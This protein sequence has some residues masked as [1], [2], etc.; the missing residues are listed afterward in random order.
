M[1]EKIS[2]SEKE[3]MAICSSLDTNKSKGADRLP[4]ILLQK[5]GISLSH[6]LAQIFRKSVQTCIFPDFWK[7]P[8][9]SPPFRKGDSHQTFQLIGQFRFCASRQIFLS[10][11][12]TIN[13][14]SII[15]R[16][17]IYLIW[18]FE[19]NALQSSR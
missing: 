18:G 7:T 5:M 16:I 8:S 13:S 15:R 12:N 1:T 10:A 19:E 11:F 2:V 9:V 17:C 4:P 14:M 3:I 6:S